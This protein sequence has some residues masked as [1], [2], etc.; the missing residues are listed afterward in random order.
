MANKIIERFLPLAI[1]Q[2]SK[3]QMLHK[4]GAVIWKNKTVLGA[5]FNRFNFTSNGN[6]SRKC[7]IHSEKDALTCLR[8]DQIYGAS[9]LAIRINSSN[10]LLSAA[11]CKGCYKLL[12]RKGLSKIYWYDDNLN[13]NCTYLN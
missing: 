10:N 1:Q 4:H 7:S 3:S 8:Q 12:N 5:G 6:C 9:M 11:P 2:A 13:L